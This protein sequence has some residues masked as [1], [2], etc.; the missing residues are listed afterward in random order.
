M[1]QNGRRGLSLVATRAVM[2]GR[3]GC[4]RRMAQLF[5]M[6]PAGSGG[7]DAHPPLVETL[8]ALPDP[9]VLLSDRRIGGTDGTEPIDVVLI[10]PEIGVALIDEAPRD[11]A[12]ALGAF[13]TYLAA[14]RFAAFYPGELPVVTLSIA[15]EQIEEIGDR[16]AAAFEAAPRLT[17]ADNDWADAVIELL[18]TPD[19]LP[20]APVGEPIFAEAPLPRP[21]AEPPVETE[22]P[23][24][25]GPLVEAEPLVETEP[26]MAATRPFAIPTLE[27]RLEP[28]MAEWAYAAR[29]ERAPRWRAGHIAAVA[30]LLLFAGVGLAAWNLGDDGSTGPEATASGPREAEALVPPQPVAPEQKVAEAPPAPAPAPPPVPPAPPVLLSAKSM[31]PLP[32]APPKPTPVEPLPQIAVIET[33]PPPPEPARSAAPPARESPPPARAPARA[34]PSSPGGVTRP[35]PVQRAV[36]AAPRP[37]REAR[38]TPPR[39]LPAEPSEAG[40]PIDATDLPPLD[41]DHPPRAARPAAAQA[42]AVAA[43]SPG[44]PAATAGRECRPYTAETP[45]AGRGVAVQ[46][47]ACRD[48]DGTWRLVSEVPVH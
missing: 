42:P 22:P 43:A 4:L 28:M 39:Q 30:A 1:E 8:L 34:V 12:G 46:G 41:P 44:T 31:A 35:A 16:L 15:P 21:V 17:V 29:E 24:E 2:N 18:L 25:A 40:P 5:P 26:E 9:W 7:D 38:L 47:I 6:R 32:P 33:A 20:M 37:T 27:T 14:Q 10:H 13:Q 11:P 23:V 48:A 19:D 36:A 45:L 3:D